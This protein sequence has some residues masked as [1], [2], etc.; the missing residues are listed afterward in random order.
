M[1]RKATKVAI[2]LV[3]QILLLSF[4]NC[5][6]ESVSDNTTEN[7]AVYS[8]GDFEYVLHDDGSAELVGYTG[9]GGEIVIPNEL[10]GHPIMAVQGNPFHNLGYG[11]YSVGVHKDHP[12]LATIDGVLFGKADRKVICFPNSLRITDYTVP[13]GIQ[14]IGDY[15]FYWCGGLQRITLPSS[16]LSIGD[17]AFWGCH[18]LRSVSIPDGVN[19][20]GEKAF[21]WSN[22]L[23]TVS[24]PDTVTSI[25]E[26]VFCNSTKLESVIISD[27][28][29]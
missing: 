15:A 19:L 20:I 13:E 18:G 11:T 24:I 8:C 16:L 9:Q 27:S 17:Y 28:Q 12:Y 2:M 25:G 23:S 10:N 4:S 6:A 29:P 1:S 5:W 22:Q 26:G 14:H 21:A 7:D 3:I